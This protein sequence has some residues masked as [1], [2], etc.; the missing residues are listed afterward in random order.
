M[1]GNWLDIGGTAKYFGVAEKTVRRWIAASE[2]NGLSAEKRRGK[3]YLDVD[4]VNWHEPAAESLVTAQKV[5]DLER[6]LNE[7][8]RAAAA[9]IAEAGKWHGKYEETQKLL[10]HQHDQEQEKLAEIE[11]LKAELA[12]RESAGLMKRIFKAW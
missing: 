10:T 9:A 8:K 7:E 6:R 3:W 12:K 2:Q 11:R 1:G 4:S 5:A